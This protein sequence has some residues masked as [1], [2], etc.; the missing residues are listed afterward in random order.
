[1]TFRN[2]EMTHE[3][4]LAV[5]ERD[6]R[7]LLQLRDDIE[8]ILFPG[9]WGLFGGHLN[10]GETPFQAVNRELVEEINWAPEN[11]LVPWFSIH[12]STL[13]VH[14]F[15]GP[16]CVSLGQLQLLEG[17]DMTL[18]TMEELASGAIWSPRLGEFRPTAPGLDIV[19][20]RQLSD[21][22]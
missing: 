3:V 12:S 15:R 10:A 16:L 17:Q 9:H 14:V 18:A 6:G 5:L 13:V 2:E 1:M 4:S 20:Q 8:G 22:D 21:K 7:W 19:L 11:F